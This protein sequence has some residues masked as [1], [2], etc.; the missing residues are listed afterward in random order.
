ML[1]NILAN[2]DGEPTHWHRSARQW[3]DFGSPLRPC[4]E[5]LRLFGEMLAATT[6]LLDTPRKQRA[7]LL[8]MGARPDVGVDAIWQVWNVAG[9]DAPALAERRGWLPAQVATIDVYRGASARY[10]FM[11]LDATLRRLRHAGFDLV[12]QR[13]GHYELAERCPLLLLRKRTAAMAGNAA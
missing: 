7:W 3:A 12:A 8:G 11:R 2:S 13:S 6:D 5:D 1:P 9:I 4:E 10:H